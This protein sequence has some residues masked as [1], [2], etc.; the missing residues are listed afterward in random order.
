MMTGYVIAQRRADAAQIANLRL[1]LVKKM[2]FEKICI[3]FVRMFARHSQRVAEE[4]AQL[5]RPRN[6]LED[7]PTSG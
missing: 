4:A 3:P 6:L 2:H 5:R 7:N 1:A